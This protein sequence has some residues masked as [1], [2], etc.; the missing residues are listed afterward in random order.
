[1]CVTPEVAKSF[2]Q[3]KDISRRVACLAGP[4]A[5]PKLE[6]P[7][8]LE[9]LRVAR[10]QNRE[11]FGRYVLFVVCQ[12]LATQ[13]EQVIAFNVASLIPEMQENP[14]FETGIRN[15]DPDAVIAR[16]VFRF[17]NSGVLIDIEHAPHLVET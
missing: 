9:R 16:L 2:R 8:S 10:H 14:E 5:L 15:R 4:G 6:S 17:G 7:G 3:V 13:L 1:M 12:F 11:E